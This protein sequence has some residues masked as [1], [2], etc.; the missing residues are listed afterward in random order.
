[1]PHSPWVTKSGRTGFSRPIVALASVAALIILL[2]LLHRVDDDTSSTVSSSLP[3]ASPAE[4][5]G[6]GVGDCPAPLELCSDASGA[7]IDCAVVLSDPAPSSSGTSV[8]EWFLV[9]VVVLAPFVLV[10]G[11]LGW[12]TVRRTRRRNAA[13]FAADAAAREA[14]GFVDARDPAPTVFALEQAWR[15]AARRLVR[16][17]PPPLWLFE[18]E[19][20]SGAAFDRWPTRSAVFVPVATLPSGALVPMRGRDGATRWRRTLPSSAAADAVV[21]AVEAVLDGRSGQVALIVGGGLVELRAVAA[22]RAEPLAL[23]ALADVAL[24]VAAAVDSV[25]AATAPADAPA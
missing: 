4:R 15:R 1:M 8:G 3:T 13:A 24:D 20:S 6:A 2:T 17:G 25:G 10:L 5:C 19:R 22:P 7:R 23:S 21:R 12:R 18:F 14:M 11:P 16:P 9:G